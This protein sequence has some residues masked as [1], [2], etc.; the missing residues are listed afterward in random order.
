M[1]NNDMYIELSYILVS[2]VPSPIT[3]ASPTPKKNPG[4]GL[5]A[6]IFPRYLIDNSIVCQSHPQTLCPA[7]T[8]G[9]FSWKGII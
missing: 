6:E 8:L 7:K 2:A 1:Y 4:S 9:N 3:T 5:Q